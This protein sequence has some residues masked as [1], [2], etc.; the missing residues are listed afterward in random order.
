[1]FDD[2]HNGLEAAARQGSQWGGS[3]ILTIVIILFLLIC[4]NFKDCRKL[5]GKFIEDLRSDRRRNNAFDERSGHESRLTLLTVVQ[6]I[7]CGG[8]IVEA[9]ASLHNGTATP[10]S[11]NFPGIIAAIALLGAYY[12][13]QLCAYGI[14]GYTF[15][16]SGQTRRWIAALNSTQSLAGFA[17]TV[18][19]LVVLFYP[20]AA[21]A[22]AI[23]GA[24]VYLAARFIFIIKGF[25]IFYHNIFSPLYFIL[26][27]CALEIIPVIYMLKL[28]ML[29]D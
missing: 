19:A 21:A 5:S 24:C 28:A 2:W 16:Q 7:V 9:A 25:T 26:Y 20:G 18:P 3:A 12:I 6:S 27:L 13:F 23:V 1:M 22:V 8:I 17:L 15:A 11:D 14:T 10:G 29:I 4:I